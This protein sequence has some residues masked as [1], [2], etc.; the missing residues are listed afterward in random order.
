[1]KN[2]I[3]CSGISEYIGIYSL[4][5]PSHCV[6]HNHHNN[7]FKQQRKIKILVKINRVSNYVYKRIWRMLA[8]KAKFPE[9]NLLFLVNEGKYNMQNL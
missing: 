9:R 6:L 8:L 4:N 5:G 2:V 1:M 7:G 3:L